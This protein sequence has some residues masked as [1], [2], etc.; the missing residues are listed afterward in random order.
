MDRFCDLFRV[1]LTVL[2]SV[3]CRLV[4]TCLERTDLLAL[5]YMLLL[6]LSRVGWYVCSSTDLQPE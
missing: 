1:C 3:I 2:Y 6:I 5:R 4:V